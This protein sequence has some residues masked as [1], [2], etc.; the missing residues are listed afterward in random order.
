MFH[1]KGRKKQKYLLIEGGASEDKIT[2]IQLTIHPRV[3]ARGLY[4]R[5]ARVAEQSGMTMTG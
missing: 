4:H 5:T 3:K 1:T 2:I